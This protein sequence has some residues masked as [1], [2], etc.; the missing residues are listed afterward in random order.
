[1]LDGDAVRGEADSLGETTPIQGPEYADPVR[2]ALAEEVGEA[3]R[4]SPRCLPTKYLYYG[5]GSELFDAITRSPAYYLTHAE[6]EIL[7]HHAGRIAEVSGAACLVELGS[8]YARKT[9][10]LLDALAPTLRRYVPIDISPDALDEASRC[11]AGDYPR[12]EVVPLVADF[13]AAPIDFD[14][15]HGPA[16]LVVLGGTIGSFTPPERARLLALLRA[17]MR[18]EDRLLIGADLVKAVPDMRLRRRG[19]C[20]RRV[21][22][23][24]AADSQP[25]PGRRLRPVELRS[26]R[27]LEPER[28]ARRAHT[29]RDPDAHDHSHSRTATHSPRAGGAPAHGDL[30]EVPPGPARRRAAGG[31]PDPGGPVDRSRQPVHAR[32]DCT[33]ALTSRYRPGSAGPALRSR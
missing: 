9:R 19:R 27:E 28:R 30:P 4:R 1:M 5:N 22:P 26:H 29:A 13:L 20:E 8:G 33:R 2:A 7:A 24:R 14:H 3:L 6:L 32:D 18:P 17:A 31:G 11:L 16:L 12:L 15:D 25:A 23:E 21:Q 10:L